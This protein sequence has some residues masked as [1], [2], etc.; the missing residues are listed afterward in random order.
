MPI[1][2]VSPISAVPSR[3][4]PLQFDFFS[5]KVQPSYQNILRHS[6]HIRACLLSKATAVLSLHVEHGF[7]SSPAKRI[8]YSCNRPL[9]TRLRS[10]CF[11]RNMR[12]FIYI[13]IF[14]NLRVFLKRLTS[15]QS[16]SPSGDAFYFFRKS[17]ADR[18]IKQRIFHQKHGF[19]ST[20]QP[21]P[22]SLKYAEFTTYAKRKLNQ[23]RLT[24]S[25]R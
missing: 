21:K 2:F 25:Q 9:A 20:V 7:H 23:I 12:S 11:T 18:P 17:D 14:C 13:H 10:K 8:F 3:F 24:S 19:R 22:V 1:F 4:S 5:A 15:I 6:P 16:I